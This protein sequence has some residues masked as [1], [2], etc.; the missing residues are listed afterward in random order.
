VKFAVPDEADQ[1]HVL[2]AAALVDSERSAMAVLCALGIGDPE[3]RAALK[4]EWIE[5]LCERNI[6]PPSD[7]WS[8]DLRRAIDAAKAMVTPIYVQ[9][10]AFHHHYDFRIEFAGHSV[11][12]GGEQEE[13]VK[14][15]RGAAV[16][17]LAALIESIRKGEQR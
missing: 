17:L 12:I 1:P 15:N 16:Q 13:I 11:W 10:G 7:A 6:E 3:V 2:D 9:M 14:R 8:D 4:Q 5:S